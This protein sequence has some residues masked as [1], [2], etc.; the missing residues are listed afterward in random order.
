MKFNF[1]T[2]ALLLLTALCHP[3][4]AQTVGSCAVPPALPLKSGS[5]LTVKG[6]KANID[7]VGTQQE[8]IRLICDLKHQSDAAKIKISFSE[9]GTANVL[10]FQG[11]PKND[12]GIRIEVPQNT[13]LNLRASA[14]EWKVNQVV[15]NKDIRLTFGDISVSPV[16]QEEYGSVE[17]STHI[18]D[19][20][21]P[22][23]DVKKEDFFR[24]FSKNTSPGKYHLHAHVTTGDIT[25]EAPAPTQAEQAQPAKEK[26]LSRSDVVGMIAEDRKIVTP[27]GIEKLVPVQINGTTQWLSIRGR[28]KRNP[29]LLFLHGGPGLTFMPTAWTIQSPW[30][31]YFT[32]V[33]WDQR[34][35][36][37]TYGSNDPKALESSMTIDQ[38]TDDAGEVVR[39]LQKEYGKQKIFLL[40]HSWGTV[41]GVALAQ[42]HPDWFYAYIGVGQFVNSRR[43]EEDGYKFAL[44]QARSHGN[45]DAEKELLAIAPYPGDMSALGFDKIGAERKW[46]AYYGGVA[47]GRASLDFDDGVSTLSP[48][49]TQK[50]LD[51]MGD[52][53]VFSASH[54]LQSLMQLDNTAV[55]SFE[56][57]VFLFEGRH[58]YATSHLL[59]AEWF[60]QV[61]APQKEL[62]WFENS[63][64]MVMEEEPGKFFYHLATDVR[65]LAAKTGDTAPSDV[66]LTSDK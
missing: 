59:A 17:A 44:E 21:V 10:H 63:A 42:R 52:A 29:I 58:D 48:D 9:T 49:Y 36:G 18:G 30:E 39:Y 11:G 5:V 6:G 53:A 4:S 34:G 33:Q 66:V 35:A 51:S 8:G 50:D 62:V 57:P 20:N 43:N 25:L 64:H 56:C 22:G 47:Y 46:V 23:K 61:K 24:S 15:G 1:G 7:V 54:L 31:D 40:G 14:G 55:T 32:V 26:P 45:S 65:P 37:K 60:T 16:T 3:G 28:D 27:N 41:L 19:V 38:M 2:P 12:V 13:D